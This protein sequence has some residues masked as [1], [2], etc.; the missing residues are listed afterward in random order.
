[1]TAFLTYTIFGLVVGSIYAIAASG[2]VLTYTTSGIFNFAHGAQAMIGAF[3]YYQLDVAWGLPT[4]L[5]LVLV[6]GVLGPG[7]GLLL[8]TL[9]MRRLRDT[10][11]VTRIVV[12]VAVLLGLVALAQWAWDPN[13]SRIPPMLFGV[14][15]TVTLA[16]VTLR[17]HQVLCLVLA[18]LLAVV[19]RIVFT[20]TRIGVVMRAT[21]DDPDLLRLTG[22]DPERVSTAAWM[23]GSVLAVL[24][25]VLITPVIGGT[26]EANS[27]TL[28]VVDAFAAALFGR[29][30]SIPL[31]F[32]GAIVLGLASTYLVGYAPTQWTW[33]SNLQ[34]ALPMVV[35][36][37]VLLFLPHDRLR[38]AGTRTRERYE[39]PTGRR[40]AVWAVVFVV[41]VLAFRQLIGDSV[42]GLLSTGIAF[43]IIALSVTLLT[44]YAGELNLAP[45]AFSAVAT[46]V[47]YHLGAH[48]DGSGARMSVGGVLAG[49]LAAAATGALVSLPALRLRGLYLA[50][51]TLAFGVFVSD[52]LLRDTLPHRLFGHT[53]SIFPNGNLL[54]PPL[55]VGPFDLADQD[56]LLLVVSVLFASLGLTLVVIRNS[57]FGRRLA[58]MKDS[59]IATATLG[60]RL[61]PLKVGV[62]ALSTGIAGLG[63]VFMAMATTSVA[64][65]TF[66]FTVSLSV[67]M[68]TVVGGIGYVGGALAGGLIAGAGTT[69]IASLLNGSAANHPA[70]AQSLGV[71]S[72]L[73]LVSAALAGIGVARNPSG[74]LHQVFAGHRTLAKAP[75]IRYAAIAVQLCVYLLAWRHVMGTPL[76]L[77]LSAALWLALPW[78]GAV[79]RPGKLGLPGRPTPPELLGIDADYPPDLVIRLDRQLGIGSLPLRTGHQPMPGAGARVSSEEAGH[80]PA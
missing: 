75:E 17:Y 16:G 49:V 79:L 28:L 5:S 52:M 24:A 51:A 1:M 42:V 80:V 48:G 38:G 35:L 68:L 31:T 67:V 7:M 13:V 66:G 47:A 11:P 6:L 36:F 8:H 22:H 14:G 3:V 39:V 73:V 63:G 45:L 37:A 70:Y 15:H 54:V 18:V 21:V 19:L 9:V 77:L 26:L 64:G 29:L 10:E 27:L 34:Q 4:W 72:H 65:D 59:P 40:A 30:R 74:V 25:G 55:R 41:V 53:F 12:T 61:I 32:V 57:G 58:A 43:A 56:T 2:L 23:S 62:F 20:R 33:V 78:I 46:L 44:G 50:L 76:F 71:V 69:A 60:Q